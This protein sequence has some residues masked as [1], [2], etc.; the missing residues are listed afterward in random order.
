MDHDGFKNADPSVS[1]EVHPWQSFGPDMSWAVAG[2]AIRTTRE[3]LVDE[4]KKE[5]RRAKYKQRRQR[6]KEKEDARRAKGRKPETE[7]RIP[8]PQ[9]SQE[10]KVKA[11]E[12]VGAVGVIDYLWRLRVGTNYQDAAVFTEGPSSE[13][14]SRGVY[15]AL[16]RLTAGSLMVHELHVRQLIGKDE[17]RNIV[18]EWLTRVAKRGKTALA[19]RREILF[20]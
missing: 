15:K 7:P 6:W 13:D 3:R 19:L 4:K 17:M 2:K 20:S 12:L 10:E 8:K 9:L 14:E 1:M 5:L 11:S 16:L 18:D